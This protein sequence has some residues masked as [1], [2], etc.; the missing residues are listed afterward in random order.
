MYVNW[1]RFYSWIQTYIFR[2]KIRILLTKGDKHRERANTVERFRRSRES[3]AT[4]NLYYELRNAFTGGDVS[5]LSAQGANSTREWHQCED[6]HSEDRR[7]RVHDLASRYG[8]PRVLKSLLD[9][10]IFTWYP[11]S[12]GNEMFKN[13]FILYPNLISLKGENAMHRCA[14]WVNII[15]VYFNI[16]NVS[17]FFIKFVHTKSDFINSFLYDW[18][19]NYI[20]NYTNRKESRARNGQLLLSLREI[21]RGPF[22]AVPLAEQENGDFEL[23]VRVTRLVLSYFSF[24]NA[25]RPRR[26]NQFVEFELKSREDRIQNATA[27]K[28]L[29]S[30]RCNALDLARN[31][32]RKATFLI[33]STDLASLLLTTVGTN[34]NR[35]QLVGKHALGA[36]VPL[37][38]TCGSS[39]QPRISLLY[40]IFFLRRAADTEKEET[41]IRGVYELDALSNQDFTIKLYQCVCDTCYCHSGTAISS[42]CE[43]LKIN[44]I[45]NWN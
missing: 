28:I 13:T 5:A 19:G 6:E 15:P 7:S 45:I 31:G 10:L 8:L 30:E 26:N 43:L 38:W 35:S 4:R 39:F 21:S 29:C 11:F 27:G 44:H 2:I 12:R 24:D 42:K 40:A 16:N 14:V 1:N 17:I 37:A 34:T 41:R 20:V 3:R 36:H 9:W 32:R 18:I 22:I 23:R 33:G 25:A